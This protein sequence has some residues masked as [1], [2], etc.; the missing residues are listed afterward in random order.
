MSTLFD[1]TGDSPEDVQPR[2]KG[3]KRA[4]AAPAVGAV[5]EE[6]SPSPRV[7]RVSRRIGVTDG[8]PCDGRAFG[9]PCISTVWDVLA[10]EGD[11][12]LVGCWVC[13]DERWMDAVPGV[14]PVPDGSGAFVLRAGRFAGMSLAEVGREPRGLDTLRIYA[15]GH[16]SAAVMEAAKKYLDSLG[17]RP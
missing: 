17:V 12:W 9:E 16:Q 15:A 1:L 10:E 7:V 8:D 6:P 13:G 5:V 3:K 14:L 4:A 11:R 2:R